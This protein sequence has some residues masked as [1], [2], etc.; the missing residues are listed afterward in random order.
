MGT[1]MRYWK[2]RI[3]SSQH[4]ISSGIDMPASIVMTRVVPSTGLATMPGNHSCRR[5]ASPARA[6]TCAAGRLMR[7]S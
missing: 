5:G 3:V 2:R 7:I 4:T 1:V 6:H